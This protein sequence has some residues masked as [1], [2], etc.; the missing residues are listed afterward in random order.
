MAKSK[1]RR[2]I[3]CVCRSRI[4][5]FASHEAELDR[6][7]EPCCLLKRFHGSGSGSGAGAE[8]SSWKKLLEWKEL[9]SS[10]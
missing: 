4:S 2:W 6:S 7:G 8:D 1:S 10:R 5:T 3:C 9:F